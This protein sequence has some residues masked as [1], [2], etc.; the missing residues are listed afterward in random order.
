M[1]SRLTTESSP[2]SPQLEKACA[3][4]WRSSPAND[5]LKINKVWLLADSGGGLKGGS[6]LGSCRSVLRHSHLPLNLRSP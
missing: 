6:V 2:H 3:Q 1:R 5:K 4:Q